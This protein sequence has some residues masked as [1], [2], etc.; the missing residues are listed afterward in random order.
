[1]EWFIAFLAGMVIGCCVGALV[2]GLLVA[3]RE[4]VQRYR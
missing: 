1:M 3:S 4:E 2:M